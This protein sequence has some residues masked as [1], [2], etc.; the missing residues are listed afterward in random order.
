VAKRRRL[1][2]HQ[3]RPPDLV[4]VSPLKDWTCTAC[5]GTGD[6][7]LMQDAGPVCLRC[8]GLDHL[9]FLPSGDAA[10]TR[11]AHRASDMSAVVVRF[12]RNRKRYERQ[13]LLVEAAALAQAEQ[14]CPA[15]SSD[16]VS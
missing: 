11:R 9:V 5:S 8:A 4:V 16:G 1:T 2:E 6:L 12:S 15:P 14:R 3:S 13:G 7:L 10:L